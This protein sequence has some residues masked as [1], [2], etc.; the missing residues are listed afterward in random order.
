MPFEEHS[1][2]TIYDSTNP[3]GLLDC[4]VKVYTMAD[5]YDFL[6]VRQ[7]V[8]SVISDYL[9][10]DEL[11]ELE[12]D[13]LR[14]SLPE[15]PELIARV[16]GPNAPHLADTAMRDSLFDWL[17]YNFGLAAD[18]PGFKVKLEDGSLLDTDLIKKLPFKLSERIREYIRVRDA[19]DDAE[20]SE[21][22]EA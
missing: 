11:S 1:K 16:C 21:D 13:G 5:K 14:F 3:K 2:N 22:S 6:S 4:C 17:V 15:L 12:Y 20:D 18:D 9:E 10:I 8:V 19:R 7:A